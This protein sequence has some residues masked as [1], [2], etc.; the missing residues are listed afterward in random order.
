MVTLVAGGG[1]AKRGWPTRPPWRCAIGSD[2]IFA[3]EL[4]D[5]GAADVGV[6]MANAVLGD[7]PLARAEGTHDPIGTVET[8]CRADRRCWSWTTASMSPRWRGRS[9]RA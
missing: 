9:C 7:A 5:G 2:G 4:A 3:I 6:R 8:T 1:K